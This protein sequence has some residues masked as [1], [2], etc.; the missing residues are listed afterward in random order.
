MKLRHL[1]FPAIFIAGVISYTVNSTAIKPR[2]PYFF[3][4]GDSTVARAY[5]WGDGFF[6]NV[7]V[8]ADGKNYGVW[9]STTETFRADKYWERLLE[10]V[11]KKRKEH[12]LPVVMMQFGH[13]H[14]EKHDNGFTIN[15]YRA[16]LMK[17]TVEV[18]ARGGIAIV[19]TPLPHRDYWGLRIE[20]SEEFEDLRRAALE[21]GNFGAKTIDLNRE[22]IDY[23]NSIGEGLARKYSYAAGDTT[24]L[25][26]MGAKVF[27]RMVA[28][29]LVRRVPEL[30]PYIQRQRG[31]ST[32]IWAGQFTNGEEVTGPFNDDMGPDLPPMDVETTHHLEL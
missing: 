6:R 7:K 26:E 31:V 2:P 12:H 14:H 15:R 3:L 20:K 22:A 27:G 23:F 30:S 28:D 18:L 25:N 21:V 11:A 13:W 1:L 5:G 19:L 16:D 4:A 10:Q 17:M 24:H 32:R 29:L 8:S 9:G